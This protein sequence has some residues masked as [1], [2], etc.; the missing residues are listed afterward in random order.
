MCTFIG[1]AVVFPNWTLELSR[2]GVDIFLTFRLTTANT[3]IIRHKPT[4]KRYLVAI[5]IF[6]I[7]GLITIGLSK[8]D[9]QYTLYIEHMGFVRVTIEVILLALVFSF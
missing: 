5:S 4:S 9:N 6:F 7:L 1:F 2:Y 3:E 8:I